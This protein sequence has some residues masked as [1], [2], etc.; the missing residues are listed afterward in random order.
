MYS[1]SAL[2]RS[3]STSSTL[4][5]FPSSV[6]LNVSFTSCIRH[7]PTSISSISFSSSIS[8]PSAGFVGSSLFKFHLSTHLCNLSCDSFLR[9]SYLSFTLDLLYSSLFLPFSVV[10]SAAAALSSNQ[11]LLSPL[12]IFSLPYLTRYTPLSIAVLVVP[13][14]HPLFSILLLS[15]P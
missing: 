10:F 3:R 12:D 7:P 9:T 6:F 2:C 11:F 5:A 1:M 14:S 8:S 15:S 13:I 4:A